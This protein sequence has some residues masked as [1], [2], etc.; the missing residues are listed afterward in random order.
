MCQFASLT[1]CNPASFTA[2]NARVSSLNAGGL[3]WVSWY[4]GK[5]ARIVNGMCVALSDESG[6]LLDLIGFYPARDVKGEDFEHGTGVDYSSRGFYHRLIV[7]SAEAT[8]HVR[9]VSLDVQPERIN[10]G[11]CE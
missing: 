10:F 5:N 6:D 1:L 9:I 4:S 8:V 2:K 11:A 7:R 3:I